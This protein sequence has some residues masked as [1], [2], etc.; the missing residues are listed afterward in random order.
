MAF[1]GNHSS[2]PSGPFGKPNATGQTFGGNA[3]ATFP[4]AFSGALAASNVEP[5]RRADFGNAASLDGDEKPPLED[6]EEDEEVEESIDDNE[7]DEEEE[8]SDASGEE[9]EEAGEE[10]EEDGDERV[11]QHEEMEEDGEAEDEAARKSS[12]TVAP[13]I[14]ESNPF[15]FENRAFAKQPEP[16][17]TQPL[18]PSAAALSSPLIK[19]PTTDPFRQQTPQFGRRTTEL[20]GPRPIPNVTRREQPHPRNNDDPDAAPEAETLSPELFQEMVQGTTRFTD[21]KAP[22]GGKPFPV[23]GA[24]VD[25][26]PILSFFERRLPTSHYDAKLDALFNSGKQ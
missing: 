5:R 11:T 19:M 26:A 23:R 14:G 7:G 17:S 22:G 8:A 3:V 10:E 12:E 1:S 9:Y 15:R 16:I 24:N 6:G 18:V 20:Q 25:A 21:I 13:A 4:S 2:A